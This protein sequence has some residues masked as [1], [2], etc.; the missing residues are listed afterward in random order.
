M[1]FIR[2]TLS[3][4]VQRIAQDAQS[5]L[6]DDELSRSDLS[7]FIRV[8]AGASHSIYAAIEYYKDQLFS[9]SAE[10]SYLERRAAIFNLVRKSASHAKGKVK[11]EFYSDPV[12]VPV[13]TLLQTT[14]GYQYSTLESPSDE[15][16][17]QVSAVL[18]GSAYNLDQGQ[19]LSLVNSL[20]GVKSA[21]TQT[22]I[23]GGTDVETDDELRARV[24][25]R[26]QN[27]PRQGTKADYEAWALE[28]SGVGY[29]WCYPKEMGDGSVTIRILDQDGGF[30]DT[31]LLNTVRKH[32][33]G[34]ASVLATIYVE[35]P[36]EQ[37][38]NLTL[39]ITP[40]TLAIRDAA[41]SALKSLFKKESVPGSSI[42][43]SHL[44]ACLSSVAGETDH[45][46]VS[47]VKDFTASDQ[48]H[49]LTLGSVTW[50]S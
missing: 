37:K 22:A 31:T 26:T 23:D 40:D 13:G 49:L 11:F 29:A 17:A 41:E 3:E 36:L 15:F 42:L 5:R 48:A 45:V 44:N 21:V 7:V 10:T 39:K 43:L 32:V 24:L 19:T 2:P 28:V 18:G 30:P 33:T 9:D 38:C 25:A 27:P 14:D 8:L 6:T 1:N 4:I 47:P 46:I 12:D 35:S 34:K 16:V 20:K 50:Q